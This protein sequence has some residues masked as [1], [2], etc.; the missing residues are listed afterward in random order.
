[1]AESYQFPTTLTEGER[2]FVN[3]DFF[4]L[5]APLQSEGGDLAA[6]LMTNPSKL[7]NDMVGE[8]TKI[9]ETFDYSKS[10]DVL[11]A[12]IQLPLQEVPSEG[13]ALEYNDQS[14]KQL[15]NI[16]SMVKSAGTA[17]E[18]GGGIVDKLKSMFGGA[19]GAI[20]G[21]IQK[22]LPEVIGATV[23]RLQGKAMNTMQQ[24]FFVGPNKRDYSFNFELTA[25]NHKD[26]KEMSI[27]ANRF[28]YYS[29]PGLEGQG[30][31]W[32]Y[33]EVVRFFFQE[34]DGENFNRVDIFSSSE[35][36]VKGKYYESKACFITSVG[37][38]YGDDEYLR[39]STPSGESGHAKLKLTVALK[40][41][42]YFT[43]ADY[44]MDT[45]PAI[46]K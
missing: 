3:F 45:D 13:S 26:S 24:T 28:Q 14:I 41:A 23:N 9:Q 35:T 33:P 11:L 29:N 15:S 27:I 10:A 21:E 43:K 2:F 22:A 46:S 17:G 39:F 38:E 34:K 16:T 37:I 40:E 6:D 30:N 20:Q 18:A 4:K 5:A 8:L 25:R 19:S 1:M 32:T 12:T 44:R 7:T 31:F 42:E 36:A